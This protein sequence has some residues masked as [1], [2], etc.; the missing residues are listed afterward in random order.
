M[1]T[2]EENYKIPICFRENYPSQNEIDPST[3]FY[4]QIKFVNIHLFSL[5]EKN[6][7]RVLQ[8]HLP[9]DFFNQMT[10]TQYAQILHIRE[11][12]LVTLL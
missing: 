4:V 1:E 10:L 6:M 9:R 8:Q 7:T 5:R 12:N 11:N 3:F 2:A